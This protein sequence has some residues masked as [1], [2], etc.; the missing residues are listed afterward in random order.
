[1][2]GTDLKMYKSGYIWKNPI[3][4]HNYAYFAFVP[5]DRQEAVDDQNKKMAWA[6]FGEIFSAI[7]YTL[8]V[9]GFKDTLKWL[10][11]SV[12]HTELAS[13]YYNNKLKA[14]LDSD[15]FRQDTMADPTMVAIIRRDYHGSVE[16]YQNALRH[17]LYKIGT[18]ATQGSSIVSTSGAGFVLTDFLINRRWNDVAKRFNKSWFGMITAFWLIG[19]AA[20]STYHLGTKLQLA[21]GE[22]KAASGGNYTAHLHHGVSAVMGGSL[23]LAWKW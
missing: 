15:T 4:G 22:Q 19:F 16:V 5:G 17:Q 2:P 23:A 9:R 20:S 11:L 6:H 3:T 13:A 21:Y 10:A 14:S 7:S 12:T 18:G 1:M 8:W